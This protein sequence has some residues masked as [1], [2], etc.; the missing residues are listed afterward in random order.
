M[1]SQ[2]FYTDAYKDI[3][4]RAVELLN[5]QEEFLSASTAQS[6]RAVGDAIQDILSGNFKSILGDFSAP[7]PQKTAILA[8]C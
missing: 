7:K 1:R 3:E 4:Q 8:K 6:T 5:S 2:L